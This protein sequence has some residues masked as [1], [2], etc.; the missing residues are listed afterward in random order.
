LVPENRA[1]AS[2]RAV[3]EVVNHADRQQYIVPLGIPL[4]DRSAATERATG[5][6]SSA[7]HGKAT[8]LLLVG[9]LSF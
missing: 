6:I 7:H 4:T 1:L 3:S 5:A 9:C 2:S 8:G